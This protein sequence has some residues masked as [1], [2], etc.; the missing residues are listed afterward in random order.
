MNINDIL[1]PDCIRISDKIASKKR[2]LEELSELI[3]QHDPELIKEEIFDSLIA[4]ERL[5]S[6]GISHGVAIPHG[7]VKTCKHSLGCFV[8]LTNPVDFDAIDG[9]PV[10]LVF[11]LLV[12]ENSTDEHLKI[13]SALAN[14]FSHEAICEK[15]RT[16]SS[17]EDIYQLLTNAQI[18]EQL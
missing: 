18:S 15:L 13:L 17:I 12:P 7:R 5:G 6:T 10:D 16:S 9:K 1:S 3:S 8:K 11:G 4:R 14:L 2:V